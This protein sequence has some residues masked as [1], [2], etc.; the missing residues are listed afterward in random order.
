MDRSN[1]HKNQKQ[2]G[3]II[4]PIPALLRKMSIP[5]SMGMFFHTMYHVVDTY[6]AGK[7]STQ[8]LASLSLSL[9]VFFVIISLGT[10][11][12]AGTTALIGAAIGAG[13]DAQARRYTVQAISFGLIAAAVL[14][15][16]G[17]LSAPFLFRLLG[18]SDGYLEIC[19]AYM[20]VLF[21][22]SVFFIVNYM[23][24]AALTAKGDTKSFRNFL[25]GGVLLNI[26]LDPWFTFGGLGLPAMGI[27]GIALS[28]ILI[29]S[30]GTLY[31]GKKVY[32]AGLLSVTRIRSVLPQAKLFRDIAQQG[33]PAG[34]NMLTIAVGIF[35]ITYYIGRFGQDA[36]AAYGVG[37]RIE[38]LVLLPP[39]GLHIATLALVAQNFGAQK[40][41]RV[42]ETVKTALLYGGILTGAGTVLLLVFA[43][44]LVQSFTADA[45]VV[46]TGIGYLMVEA[47]V[48]YAYVILFVSVAAM[49]GI[50]KPMFAVVIGILRQ[51]IAPV[52]VFT[53]LT[54]VFPFGVKGIWWG[55]LI[56][57]WSAAVFALIYVRHTMKILFSAS[58]G[59]PA[60]NLKE[61]GPKGFRLKER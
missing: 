52:C 44:W 8:S 59:K 43:P 19:L 38:Q 53:L 2:N 33:L 31:L 5:A 18:A 22:G 37:M 28:T 12:S 47:F 55:I 4:E 15:L 24:N 61:F 6:F 1:Q 10:G 36:V 16:I 60:F 50:K 54:R 20:D 39:L 42:R 56:I 11:I 9:P 27:S 13:D 40:Y 34:F 23:L 21:W 58:A 46:A 41:D 48:L 45:K 3:L 32:E 25:I 14:T 26:I 51:I 17:L 49:Q 57:T 29:Q 30:L 35:V 7:I